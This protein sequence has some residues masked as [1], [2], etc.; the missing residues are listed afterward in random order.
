MMIPRLKPSGDLILVRQ[1]RP[2]V[3]ANAI[4]FPAGLIEPDEDPA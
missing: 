2:P 3:G 1:F 4:E